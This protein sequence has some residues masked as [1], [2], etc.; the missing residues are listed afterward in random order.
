MQTR[1]QMKYSFS[2]TAELERDNIIQLRDLARQL[3]ATGEDPELLKECVN[4]LVIAEK[5]YIKDAGVRA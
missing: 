4:G 1:K 2:F 5:C 3:L